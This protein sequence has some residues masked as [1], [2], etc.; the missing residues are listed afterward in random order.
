VQAAGGIVSDLDGSALDFS[1]GPTLA[2]NKGVIAA[3]PNIHGRVVDG[4]RALAT[5]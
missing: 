4:L 3:N 1:Q 2:R 5:Q